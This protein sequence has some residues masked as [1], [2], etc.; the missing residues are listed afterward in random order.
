MIYR[1]GAPVPFNKP[2]LS[3]KMKASPE[4][5]IVLRVGQGPGTVE[6]WSSDLT[7]SYVEF[8]SEYTT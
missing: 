4:V 7:T 3:A 6:Y 8:N 2:A 1:D 5:S